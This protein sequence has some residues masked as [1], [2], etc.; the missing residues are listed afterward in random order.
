M[1]EQ[2]ETP[3]LVSGDP[4]EKSNAVQ[5][6]AR[7]SPYLLGV[8]SEARRRELLDAARKHITNMDRFSDV[9]A[10][11]ENSGSTSSVQE[12]AMASGAA[13]RLVMM[14]CSQYRLWRLDPTPGQRARLVELANKVHEH[15]YK[16]RMPKYPKLSQLVEKL[17][18]NR[19]ED[20]PLPE[21]VD[22]IQKVDQL[23]S[24]AHDA[25]QILLSS[26]DPVQRSNVVQSLSR[27]P[28]LLGI[29]R[30]RR[31][32]LWVAARLSL[33]EAERARATP[34]LARPNKRK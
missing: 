17:A 30:W 29:P 23:F 13:C 11:Q 15:N 22:F 25:C 5:R 3:L 21:E 7:I 1:Q 12:I 9:E 18:L 19:L 14:L 26:A 2:H 16:D 20:A 33:M 31:R 4:I 10:M 6:L 27:V 34:E 24:A 32:E 28:E 8:I